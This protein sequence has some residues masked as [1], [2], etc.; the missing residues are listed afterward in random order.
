MLRARSA[1]GKRCATDIAN[2]FQAFTYCAFERLSILSWAENFF[3]IDS[4]AERSSGFRNENEILPVAR[5]QLR[6]NHLLP[7]NTYTYEYNVYHGY[8]ILY[9]YVRISFVFISTC[10]KYPAVWWQL[11]LRRRSRKV[12]NKKW[13]KHNV[14]Y[15]ASE[16]WVVP[17]PPS[18]WVP[19]RTT[20]IYAKIIFITDGWEIMLIMYYVFTS[21]FQI[22]EERWICGRNE[23]EAKEKAS[24]KFEVKTGK[25]RLEQDSDVLDTW[26]SSALFPFSVFGWPDNVSFFI[27]YSIHYTCV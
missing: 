23:Q 22:E 6:N 7:V 13:K 5:F 17:P 19:I 3:Q 1:S 18:F 27:T 26:F 12:K 8:S 21:M 2:F 11:L 9:I 14:L 24:K 25:I 15:A 4:N 20:R 16:K 10:V